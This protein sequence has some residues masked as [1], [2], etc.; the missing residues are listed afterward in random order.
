MTP[1][2]LPPF[3]A[4][5]VCAGFGP[6][7]GGFLTTLTRALAQEPLESRVAPGLPPQI[8]CYERADDISFG[9]YF[10]AVDS[11]LG[12]DCYSWQAKE[13]CHHSGNH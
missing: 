5:I 2:A 10:C 13:F 8:I 6:A 12:N 1:E 7:A 4:D 9:N 11:K 3:D